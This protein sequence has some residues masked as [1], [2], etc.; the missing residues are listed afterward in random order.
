M[1]LVERGKCID[2]GNEILELDGSNNIIVFVV[3]AVDVALA[4]AVAAGRDID[5]KCDKEDLI[6]I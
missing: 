3:V 4:V 6:L 1:V 2:D 5:G